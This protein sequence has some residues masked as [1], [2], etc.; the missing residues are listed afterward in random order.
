[1]WAR[2]LEN[3][4][5]RQTN[6]VKDL[7]MKMDPLLKMKL[8]NWK[9]PKCKLGLLTSMLLMVALCTPMSPANWP[10]FRGPNGSGV[11]D[12]R[13]L[14][15]EFG[16]EKN[17][18]WKVSLP[19]GHSS[20][21]TAGDHVFL[22]ASEKDK[23][24]TLCVDRKSGKLLW[25][26]EIV[27]P[28]SASLHPLNSPASP[29]P[30]TDGENVYV[31]FQ[32]FGLISYAAD[33]RERWRL[34][35]GPFKNV[36]GMGTSPI[37]SHGVVIQVCD[38]DIGSFVEAANK[39]MGEMLWRKERPNTLA[40]GYSTPVVYEG[41]R[42]GPLVIAPAGFQSVAYRLDSGTR[43]W[44]VNGF[45][46]QPN[47]SPIVGDFG[48]YKDTVFLNV[49]GVA[50]LTLPRFSQLLASFDKDKNGNLSSQEIEKEDSLGGPAFSQ[51]DLDGD[52]LL[53]EKE[54]NFVTEA[55]KTKD[56]LLAVRPE[57]GQGDLTPKVLWR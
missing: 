16:P 47:A 10:R 25:R 35:L 26:R 3:E 48:D 9:L 53:T 54:W 17:V 49:Q 13:N 27:R 22:T 43:V 50:D 45:P 34:P 7:N 20:P 23:L 2:Y 14:P 5:Q 38:Q 29:S 28:R 21:V 32:D 24:L 4:C 51:A 37:V 44:W 41:F 18:R 6:S 52:G 39:E 31:F 19:A 57:N 15:V 56:L 30:A 12:A 40:A 46:A 55:V 36:N 42:E 1:M 11:S 33:G 8:G